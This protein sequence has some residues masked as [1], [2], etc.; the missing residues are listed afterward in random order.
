MLTSFYNLKEHISLNLH[1]VTWLVSLHVLQRVLL[2]LH[3]LASSLTKPLVSQYPLWVSANFSCPA[4]N[5]SVF[6]NND[7]TTL[8]QCAKG[9]FHSKEV[10]SQVTALIIYGLMLLL[11][12]LSTSYLQMKMRSFH[13]LLQLSVTYS[14]QCYILSLSNPEPK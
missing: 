2:L 12:T 3:L 10:T 5:Q 11:F 13:F 6:I 8:S 7:N 14:L 1:F 4:I 9:S